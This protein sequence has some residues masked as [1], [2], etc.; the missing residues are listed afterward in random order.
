[1]K[2]LLHSTAWLGVK[3][4]DRVEQ[5]VVYG[6]PIGTFLL[7]E[8]HDRRTVG[9]RRQ[10]DDALLLQSPDLFLE[11]GLEVSWNRIHFHP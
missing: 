6:H 5:A 4:C 9:R 7:L 8:Y 11:M 10:P 2:V 1:M 3:D